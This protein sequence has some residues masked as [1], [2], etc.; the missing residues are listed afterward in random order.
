[1]DVEN[2]DIENKAELKASGVPVKM[3]V[4]EIVASFEIKASGGRVEKRE[5]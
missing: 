5:K 3:G 2:K 1:M 4:A